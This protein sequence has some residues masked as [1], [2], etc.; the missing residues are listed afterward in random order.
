M[1]LIVIIT[2]CMIWVD[3]DKGD[4]KTGLEISFLQE[5]E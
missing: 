1:G 3:T 5:K 2:C 4:T